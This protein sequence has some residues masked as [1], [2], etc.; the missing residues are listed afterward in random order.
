[1][2]FFPLPPF[3]SQAW[4][5]LADHY[6]FQLKI[7]W[8]KTV[9]LVF[10]ERSNPDDEQLGEQ[11]VKDLHRTGCSNF[12]GEENEEDRAILKRLLLAYARWNKRVGYCQGF[13]VIAALL[14]NVMDRRE[15]DALK[16]MIYLIDSVL[17]ESYFANNLRALSV[18]MAV[19]RDLLRL[20]YPRLSNHLDKLQL[21]AQDVRTGACYE[22][23]LPNVFTMQWFLTLFAT[24]LPIPT[25][26]RV[27]DS[28]L[29]E[30][31]EILLRTALTIWGKLAKRIMTASSADE[32]YC[33]MGEL[34]SSIMQGSI[35]EGDAMIKSIYGLGE[36]PFPQ[37]HELR[38]KYT[39]NIRPFTPASS[40]S[41]NGGNQS[42]SRTSLK[43]LLHLKYSEEED[44]DDDDITAMACMPGDV[45]GSSDIS[46]LG[47]G[48][49]GEGRGSG[50]AAGRNSEPHTMERMSTDIQSLKMQYER[51]KQRQQ[52]AHIIIAAASAK[53]A[54]PP[55]QQHR[56]VEPRVTAPA[57][58][59][60]NIESPTAM[61]HLFVG[62]S[63]GAGSGV[64]SVEGSSSS[65]SSRNRFVTDGPRISGPGQGY[66]QRGNSGRLCTQLQ[67]VARAQ[68]VSKS[69]RM[70]TGV[71]QS[72]S[73]TRNDDDEDDDDGDNIS[74]SRRG[75]G[76]KVPTDS[77]GV[78]STGETQQVADGGSGKQAEPQASHVSC[79]SKTPTGAKE[80]AVQAN[81]CVDQ[82]VSQ[83]V[84]VPESN[85]ISLSHE[86]KNK[87]SKESCLT[88]GVTGSGRQTSNNN[89][90][91]RPHTE[92]L[93]A[94]DEG[95]ASSLDKTSKLLE[96]QAKAQVKSNSYCSAEG[97]RQGY[98]GE[99]VQ[100]FSETPQEN[101][102]L[103]YI[104]DKETDN[105]ISQ[106]ILPSAKDVAV[107]CDID[108]SVNISRAGIITSVT[109]SSSSSTS[110]KIIKDISALSESHQGPCQTSIRSADA[111]T[112]SDSEC[113][114]SVNSQDQSEACR[115][116]SGQFVDSLSQHKGD[117]CPAR[118]SAG[119]TE[120]LATRSFSPVGNEDSGVDSSPASSPM[121]PETSSFNHLA[122]NA[123]LSMSFLDE[124]MILRVES[125]TVETC[126]ASIQDPGNQTKTEKHLQNIRVTMTMG[127][128]GETA[129]EAQSTYD[130]GKIVSSD[131]D[132][133]QTVTCG[134]SVS[135]STVIAPS[136]LKNVEKNVDVSHPIQLE[137]S[138]SKEKVVSPNLSA[139]D[140]QTSAANQNITGYDQTKQILNQDHVESQ[141]NLCDR[142]DDEFLTSSSP[143]RVDRSV[144][145]CSTDNRVDRS[146]SIC[147]T[148]S[149][150]VL[151]EAV[152]TSSPV[153]EVGYV[154]STS[155]IETVPVAETVDVDVAH[156]LAGQGQTSVESASAEDINRHTK[157]GESSAGYT[158]RNRAKSSI[159]EVDGECRETPAVN[160]VSSSSSHSNQVQ[161]R[162]A[163]INLPHTKVGSLSTVPGA[164]RLSQ[165]FNP[166][167]VKHF[168][169]NRMKAGLKL[170]LYTPSTLEQLRAFK[171]RTA[172]S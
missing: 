75:R 117:N 121:V 92:S 153:R 127:S 107:E 6:L 15:D 11:I 32:F 79:T 115:K 125:E 13:N 55:R 16:V 164:R 50:S 124:E 37:L 49:Y 141:D 157:P 133:S 89:S 86:N 123:C 71:S 128:S 43:S 10:N 54:P 56:R 158:Q 152:T 129:Y 148:D 142:R 100:T 5:S 28:I 62:K 30:G 138:G 45:S 155:V 34:T 24:C 60:A 84:S 108:S 88:S 91:H 64:S 38:E 77:G 74:V 18:D 51:L 132:T 119:G 3:V 58:L 105:I 131:L 169:T 70:R 171:P 161:S 82:T 112:Q 7:N 19:F 98:S 1:M 66:R 68:A 48:V 26:L 36:F 90:M 95:G 31:S 109:S 96:A 172:S 63:G 29:L 139:S 65:S 143:S 137:R 40:A 134:K 85:F 47:P 149:I 44:L 22:P 163:S 73:L 12:S 160:P 41:G 59:V 93:Q 130:D 135:E 83:L 99:S 159:G 103:N 35:L 118:P 27:W 136:G 167:P 110:D 4:L 81:I 113:P 102:P 72:M 106:S 2:L 53:K 144:S 23:P 154:R 42:K 150:S 69:R 25:V 21:A 33:L 39:Y 147:S 165:P 101:L 52:Q 17:P 8:D 146:V 87:E 162:K 46:V 20:T 170:G 145:M 114:A 97:L 94:S 78:A 76:D 104:P 14:L 166:F 168:N 116:D 122:K 9:R 57:L 111:S 151:L 61:N 140:I 156:F 67:A 120:P 80:N 126:Q